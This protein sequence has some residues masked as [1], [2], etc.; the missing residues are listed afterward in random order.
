MVVSR[1]LKTTVKHQL[2]YTNKLTSLIPVVLPDCSYSTSPQ[3]LFHPPLS[4][5]ATCICTCTYR[6]TAVNVVTIKNTKICERI[7]KTAAIC[8]VPGG[9]SFFGYLHEWKQ[10]LVLLL[11]CVQSNKV[12]LYTLQGK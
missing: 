9:G 12:L 2:G 3:Q 5:P 7:Q 10:I 8:D 6:P 4:A 11:A 1:E